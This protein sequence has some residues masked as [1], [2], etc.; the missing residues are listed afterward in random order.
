M[1]A[2]AAFFDKYVKVCTDSDIVKY[3]Y[4]FEGGWIYNPSSYII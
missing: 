4:Y 3:H 2:K 1:L